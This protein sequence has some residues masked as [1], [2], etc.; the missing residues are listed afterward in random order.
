[1]EETDRVTWSQLKEAFCKRFGTDKLLDSPI[2]KLSTIKIKHNENVREYIDRFNR[3]RHLC[4]NE[5]HLT[6]TITWFISSLSRGIRLEMKKATTYESLKAAFEVAM[7][8][9]DEYT[10]SGSDTDSEAYQKKGKKSSPHRTTSPTHSNSSNLG[11]SEIREIAREVTKQSHEEV[12][13]AI[14]KKLHITGERDGVR[15]ADCLGRHLTNEFPHRKPRAPLS[16][17]RNAK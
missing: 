1:M 11:P 9:K 8:I 7:D 16:P 12:L 17:P 4:P 14:E 2:R 15:C 10:A 3:I 6:H 5:P 13:Q